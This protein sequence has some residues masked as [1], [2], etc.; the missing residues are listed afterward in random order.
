M[1][2]DAVI[3]DLD[4]LLADTERLH[5]LAFQRALADQDVPLAD[6]EYD[7]VWIRRGKGL[8]DFLAQRGLQIEPELIRARKTAEYEQLVRSQGQTMPGARELLQRLQGQKRLALA[9]SSGRS[10]ATLVL[11]ALGIAGCFEY[12][13]AGDSVSRLKPFPDIFLHVAERLATPPRCCL[14]LEDAEKGVVAAYAAGM[15][16]IAVPNAHTRDNDFA[17]AT[18]VVASLHEVTL[19]MID[20]LTSPLTATG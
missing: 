17:L 8:S 14:V 7:D 6:A 3:F 19:A 10:S 12:I 2:I 13:A 18:R 11:D 15:P 4:G 1:T 9:T 16:C 5:R 20:G